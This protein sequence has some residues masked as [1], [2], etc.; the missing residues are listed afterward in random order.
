VGQVKRDAPRADVRSVHAGARHAL[1]EFHELF[2]LLEAPQER[3]E[4]ADVHGVREDGHEVVEDAR[5]LAKQGADPLCAL[6]DLNVEQLL[7]GERV[8]LLVRHH[9]HVVESV[10]VRQGLRVRLVLDELFRAAVQEANVGIGAEDL[11][12][13]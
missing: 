12:S 3:R 8:A 2:A 1:V 10:E 9:G 4:G 7:D 11:L 6:G 13:V 5:D